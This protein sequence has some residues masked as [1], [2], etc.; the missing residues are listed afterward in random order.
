MSHPKQPKPCI[1]PS[2]LSSIRADLVLEPTRPPGPQL[3]PRFYRLNVLAAHDDVLYLAASNNEITR[4]KIH[5][6]RGIVLQQL[7][8][9]TISPPTVINNVR[10]APFSTHTSSHV[11]LLTGGNENQSASG[12]LV[13]LPLTSA[14]DPSPPV[15]KSFRTRTNSAWGLDVHPFLPRIAVSSNSQVIFI[16]TFRHPQ[17]VTALQHNTQPAA[18]S[19]HNEA[20][21]NQ[22]QLIVPPNQPQQPAQ[23]NDQLSESDAG[24]STD[25][26]PSDLDDPDDQD[27]HQYH[28]DD[29][30]ERYQPHAARVHLNNIPCVS[31][32]KQGHLLASASIDCTFAVY[33]MTTS[34]LVSSY[35]SGI[36]VARDRYHTHTEERCWQTHWVSPSTVQNVDEHHKVW[37]LHSWQSSSARTWAA[38]P[39]FVC[40]LGPISPLL[41]RYGNAVRRAQT[42]VFYDDR[43]L[44]EPTHG[45][46][47]S[48]S[49]NLR[50][51][52]S[53]PVFDINAVFDEPTAS[54][55]EVSIEF[56]NKQPFA[57]KTSIT[58]DT[59][60]LL[61]EGELML[62]CFEKSIELH[63]ILPPSDPS[64]DANGVSQAA[65]QRR[66]ARKIDRIRLNTRTCR[67]L[68]VTQIIEIA[69]LSLLVCIAVNTGVL[70]VRILRSCTPTSLSEPSLFVE[71]VIKIDA[72]CGTC[73]IERPGS[74]LA[75][76]CAELWVFTADGNLQCW[77]LSR[78]EFA[79]D[80]SKPV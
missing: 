71:R 51:P 1:I 60:D 62:V 64:P 25:S 76:F 75:E 49:Q 37:S 80:I 77:E 67:Q 36:P 23:P 31:F 55:H 74:V 18:H 26:E 29:Y 41:T 40:E 2:S 43:Q 63:H 14:G 15:A 30:F 42:K 39:N 65:P 73:V 68:M 52:D 45:S 8:S 79:L 5:R 9:S 20:L 69:P 32:H 46:P 72:I 10:V 47:H 66:R 53:G 21:A 38:P 35:Q 3:R 16:Y 28:L 44:L 34:N 24:G 27:D 19:A 78:D 22:Q 56:E 33:D 54:Q 7:P 11:L 61:S 6:S 48:E 59:P 17:P 4:L 57:L 58:E 50:S 70:F 12:R 13:L